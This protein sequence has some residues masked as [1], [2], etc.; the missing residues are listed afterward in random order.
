MNVLV[1]ISRYNEDI[2]WVSELKVPY[3]IINKG[4]PIDNPNCVCIPNSTNGREAHSYVWYILQHYDNLPDSVIFLQGNPFDHQKRIIEMLDPEVIKKMPSFQPLT[5]GYTDDLPPQDLRYVTR[6]DFEGFE[7]HIMHFG[8]NMTDIYPKYHDE[9]LKNIINWCYDD[10]KYVSIRK[11]MHALF[12]V[13]YDEKCM[14]PYF[15]A[16]MF[17]IDKE[18]IRKY[19]KDFY[20]QLFKLLERHIVYVYL[21]E[22]MW[23]AMFVEANIPLPE[24]SS[25]NLVTKT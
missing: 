3:L 5:A 12:E 2:S 7:Y 15:F 4:N 22:R 16:A 25:I 6:R 23:Y 9:G 14:T 11:Q 18:L 1:V 13:P 21:C 20:A 17:K 24:D 19:S 10:L 8:E